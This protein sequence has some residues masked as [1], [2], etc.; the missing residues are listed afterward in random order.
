MFEVNDA[1]VFFA[2]TEKNNF[3]RFKN[4]DIIA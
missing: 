2:G 3:K 1:T 4:V